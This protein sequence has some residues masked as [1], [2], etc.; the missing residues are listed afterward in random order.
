MADR[1]GGSR[2]RVDSLC[3]PPGVHVTKLASG[4]W[5]VNSMTAEQLREE[6]IR[7]AAYSLWETAGRQDG[8]ADEY[9]LAAEK[10]DA[11]DAEGET[12]SEDGAVSEEIA[13]ATDLGSAE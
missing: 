2:Q 9:W 12:A 10:L 8:R 5:E 1:A 13:T 4:A 11:L 6:R 7:V 3:V